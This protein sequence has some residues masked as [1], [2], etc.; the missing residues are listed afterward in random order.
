MFPLALVLLVSSINAQFFA[1]QQFNN[2]N[3]WSWDQGSQQ[4]ESLRTSIDRSFF[5]FFFRLD[6]RTSV[7]GTL[8]ADDTSPLPFGSQIVVTLAD[9]SLQ[10]VAARPLNTVVLSGSY[11][12]PIPFEVPY[13][14]GQVQSESSFAQQYALQVRIEKDGQLLYIN[15]QRVSVQLNPPPINPINIILKRVSAPSG[16]GKL[17]TSV[18]LGFW[19]V[20]SLDK[21]A[22]YS[23]PDRRLLTGCMAVYKIRKLV[24][25]KR[26][27]PNSTSMLNHV[28]VYS[29][30]GVAVLAM[31]IA[32]VRA[33][34]A[35]EAVRPI[36][37][38]SWRITSSRDGWIDPN[39]SFR[40][41]NSNAHW[42]F[43][44]LYIEMI[45]RYSLWNKPGSPRLAL[46]RRL[47]R[48]LK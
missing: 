46:E 11:R 48:Y 7:R 9:V 40:S 36:D 43:S 3:P 14:L 4:S 27:F 20:F 25:A 44:V 31:R 30:T 35:N 24:H 34:N 37:D 13:S 5:I 18:V 17:S 39:V 38:R 19:I 33:T 15:D 45:A 1:Q 6:R 29:S 10:D 41:S 22:E 8:F 32:L 42:F 12:F 2:Y 23:P 26:A 28:R 47:R 21:Q 16:P